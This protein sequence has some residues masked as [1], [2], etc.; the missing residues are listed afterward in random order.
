[1]V[2]GVHDRHVEKVLVTGGAGFVGSHMCVAL[3][4]AGHEVA[5]ID[6]LENS[7]SVAL[8]A[9]A[10]ITGQ[11]PVLVVGDCRHRSALD[12]VMS[13]MRP[14]VVLHFA[15]LKSVAESVVDPLRYYRH[16]FQTT[17][18]LLAAMKRNEVFRIV[19]SSSATVYGDPEVLPVSE[20][21]QTQPANPY[22]A[23]KLL[24]EQMIA[25]VVRAD[26]RWSAVLLRYFNPV[27]AHRSGLIGEDPTHP[28]ANLMPYLLQVAVGRYDALPLC[29]TDYPTPD[30]TALRDYI[31]V[32]DLAE[33]HLA[34][35]EYLQGASSG[36]YTFNLGTG[37]ATSVLELIGVMRE[38][39]G[40]ELPYV[41]HE[42]RSGDVAAL[43]ADPSKAKREL[44]WVANRSLA[45]M[46]RDGW[47]WQ[48]KHP[49]GYC[50]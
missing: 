42:R 22:G 25:D 12:Q 27:G 3:L 15:G 23:T 39:T 21:V 17:A 38:V 26:S 2:A 5:V 47:A 33:G 30:G 48:S 45:D 32:M 10:E 18:Q 24:V 50:S 36:T 29:G 34:A 40:L 20:T 1:M 46:C 49:N 7:S 41:Q 35:M 9:V 19:F 13:C 16:N 11:R 43:W 14:S 4:E 6:S 44:G 8:D 37:R 28:P 31:H